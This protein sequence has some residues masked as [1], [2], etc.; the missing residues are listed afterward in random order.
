MLKYVFNLNSRQ[1]TLAI[2]VFQNYAFPLYLLPIPLP[3]FR[4]SRQ[5]L[6]SQIIYKKG[7]ITPVS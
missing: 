2:A 4:A 1:L 6:F 3:H 5:M 7:L